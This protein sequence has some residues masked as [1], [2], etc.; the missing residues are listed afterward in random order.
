MGLHFSPCKNSHIRLSE[1]IKLLSCGD[2]ESN[3]G[4]GILRT[5]RETNVWLKELSSLN[6]SMRENLE[7][8][9]IFFED[10]EGDHRTF[11][12]WKEKH[13]ND[14]RRFQKEAQTRLIS[15]RVKATFPFS[16]SDRNQWAVVV[17]R[18][19]IS[20]MEKESGFYPE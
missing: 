18:N 2:V 3:P 5:N 16:S 14:Q 4:P 13:Q 19:S 15:F 10:F 1:E 8:A 7:Q 12:S 20:G 9:K 17:S 11:Q 6:L